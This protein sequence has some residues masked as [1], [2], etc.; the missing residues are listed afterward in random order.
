MTTSV[1]RRHPHL[2]SAYVPDAFGVQLVIGRHLSHA[3]DLSQWHI[4]EVAEDRWLVAARDLA[5]WF[6]PLEP[7]AVRSRQFPTRPCGTGLARTSAP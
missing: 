1:W 7:S 3:H 4:T 6:R 5:A 2:W